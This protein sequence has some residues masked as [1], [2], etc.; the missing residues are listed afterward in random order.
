MMQA[1]GL[2]FGMSDEGGS[3][4]T[5]LMAESTD[6][7]ASL[8]DGISTRQ[9]HLGQGTSIIST[10]YIQQYFRLSGAN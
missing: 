1:S 8:L 4:K 6:V 3:T 2:G 10:L 7:H 9:E 5:G